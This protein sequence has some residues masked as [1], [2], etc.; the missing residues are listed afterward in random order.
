MLPKVVFLGTSL[1]VSYI[2]VQT[3]GMT[4]QPGAATSVRRALFPFVTLLVLFVYL[5]RTEG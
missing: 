5:R 4:A 3:E 1:S 2:K